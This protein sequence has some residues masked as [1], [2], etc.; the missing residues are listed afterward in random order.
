ME[1]GQS[2]RSQ[3]NNLALYINKLEQ[4]EQTKPKANERKEIIKIREEI[5]EI[6]KRKTIEK[7]SE[8]KLWFFENI[9]RIDTLTKNKERFK[10]VKLRMKVG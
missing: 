7:I 10:L 3:V 5:D 1:V 4:E 8:T 2:E 6:E 9:N